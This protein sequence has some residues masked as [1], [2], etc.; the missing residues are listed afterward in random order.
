MPITGTRAFN[1]LLT[2]IRNSDSAESVIN[3]YCIWQNKN[4]PFSFQKNGIIYA[5]SG[6]IYDLFPSYGSFSSSRS[7]YRDLFIALGCLHIKDTSWRSE[8]IRDH[9]QL[10]SWLHTPSGVALGLAA[11][12]PIFNSYVGMKYNVQLS[13]RYEM[14]YL[15]KFLIKS[16]P[17]Q[18]ELPLEKTIRLVA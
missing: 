4:I 6:D 15:E 11:K 3:D 1:V 10:S 17:V 5:R 8:F 7:N 13:P 18:L 16:Q 9:R 14:P 2:L 12:Q